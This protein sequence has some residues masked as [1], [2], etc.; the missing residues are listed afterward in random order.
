MTLF[1]NRDLNRLAVHSTLHQLA[2]T[3]S[4]AFSAVFLLRE[5][6]S[7]AAI[8]L[9][10]GAIIVLRFIF[11]PAVLFSVRA[12]GLR[13][14]LI[15]GTFLYSAQS[16]LLALVHGL[17]VAL[18]VYCVVAALAQAFYWTCYHAMFAT[19][20]EAVSRGSQ[21]GWRELLIGIAGILG[22]AI[23]GVMLTVAG[24]WAAF[25]VA[26]VIELAA[27]VPL[28]D[29]LE[30]PIEPTAPLGAFP[31]YKRGVLL[32]GSDGWI[33]NSS[34][35]AWSLI[36][37]QALDARYDAFGGVLAAAALA[38]AVSGLFLGRFI[39]MG[40]ARRAAWVNAATLAGTLIAKAVC[41][42]DPIP[43]I[44][45]AVGTTALGGLYVPSLMTAIYNEAKAS[46]CPLRFHFAA[47]IGWDVGGSL[48]CL[49]AAAL[50]AYGVSLQGVIMLALPMVAIQA[51][52]LDASYAE[53]KSEIALVGT[54][55]PG[56]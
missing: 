41:G 22:P 15:I 42:S 9:C 18:L 50:C 21:V 13:Y 46:S 39:D 51:F 26:G 30:P 16:P 8:F 27:I 12:I 4:S 2:W 44:A 24:P 1:T 45:V 38:G 10:L 17:G 31:F 7:P 33:Y 47:E 35:W 14:T 34:A 52:L 32:L 43:V 55:L 6:L 49:V 40:H 20:G 25:G 53:R 48:A 19:I 28:L 23:S 11:R 56:R 3:I 29:V 36:L 5:G 54:E 37:F